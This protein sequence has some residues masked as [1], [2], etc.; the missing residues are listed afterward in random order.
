M[1]EYNKE[2]ET[3][4]ILD[5]IID[6]IL[7]LSLAFY[8]LPSTCSNNREVEKLT[9]QVQMMQDKYQCIDALLPQVKTENVFG[10]DTPEKYYEINGKKYYFVVDGKIVEKCYIQ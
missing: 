2:P 6:Q 4:E 8:V 7:L 9:S 5:K 10:N 3:W 1:T